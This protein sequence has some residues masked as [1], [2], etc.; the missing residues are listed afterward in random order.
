MHKCIN[1]R[2]LIQCACALKQNIIFFALNHKKI[3]FQW[4]WLFCSWSWKNSTSASS[5]LYSTIYQSKVKYF[6][7]VGRFYRSLRFSRFFS[8]NFSQ[9]QFS[10]KIT[11]ENTSKLIQNSL[12][13][14]RSKITGYLGRVLGKIS[15]KR[16][17]RPPIFSW[18]KVFAPLFVS[19]KKSSP[20]CRWSRPG[21]PINFDPSLSCF[22]LL[23]DVKWLTDQKRKSIVN[24]FYHVED[25][26]PFWLI[27]FWAAP[28][29]NLPVYL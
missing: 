20:P 29:K 4:T 1:V 26:I 11:H 6:I 7:T 27:Y 10:N 5:K 22:F 3:W 12:F 9:S 14:D 16:S 25:S 21:Y 24:C 2:P 15:L 23:L 17:L 28:K 18:K 19:E 8:P 13:R